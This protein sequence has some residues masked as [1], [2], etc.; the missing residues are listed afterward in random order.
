MIISDPDFLIWG[1]YFKYG[2]IISKRDWF[3]NVEFS[4]LHLHIT[5]KYI[6]DFIIDTQY[7]RIRKVKDY[8]QG[9]P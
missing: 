4:I 1:K 8:K 6:S 2:N 9:I 3:W 5:F 7:K